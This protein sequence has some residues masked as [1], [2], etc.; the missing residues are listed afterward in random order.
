[1]DF[2]LE[3]LRDLYPLEE[4]KSLMYF[5]FEEFLAVSRTSY[6]LNP[7]KSM[8]ESEILKFNFA[9]KD[10]KTGKPIQYILGYTYFC[11]LKIYVN[12]HTL[13]PRQET[14]ELVQLIILNEAKAKPSKILD[15]GTGTAC[16][17]I[18]LA[19]VMPQ[20][21]Y[22]A[23]DFSE[24][25]ISLAKRNASEHQV[26]INFEVKDILKL[27]NKELDSYDIMISNPPY[28]LNSEKEL[29]YKNVLDFEPASALY[30]TDD[31]ALIFYE[32]IAQLAISNLTPG[33]R[34]YFE[35][36]ENKG[37]EVINLLKKL[38]FRNVNIHSDFHGKN[39]FVIAE[40]TF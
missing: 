32:K 36:N 18:A 28:V 10:L 39:R 17:P 2:A 26:E 19:K 20:H 7:N 5:L 37:D 6:L 3:E 13:I 22:F 29:M 14:E 34:L 12:S 30:V 24:E 38:K 23:L 16:I 4:I 31:Y 1:M 40:K 11:D 9:I 8:S 33:G 35:I 25:I 21:Q 15:L 27:E